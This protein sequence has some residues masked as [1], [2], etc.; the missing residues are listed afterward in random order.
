MSTQHTFGSLK[1]RIRQLEIEVKRAQEGER[2]ALKR[3][4]AA[5]EAART[6]WKVSMDRSTE[7]R[8]STP[9]QAERS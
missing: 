8:R 2:I 9:D 5:E 4:T 3:A 1:E 6:A 7:R